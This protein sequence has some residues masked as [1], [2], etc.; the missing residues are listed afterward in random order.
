M[1]ANNRISAALELIAQYG[2]VDG[3]HH[4][5]WLIDQVVRTLLE[6]PDKY[7]AWVENYNDPEYT[8]WDEGSAP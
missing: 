4:K 6:S 7:Q 8:E 5:Q 2:D 3:A 1:D